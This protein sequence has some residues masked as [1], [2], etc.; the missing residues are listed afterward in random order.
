MKQLFFVFIM[1]LSLLSCEST[2]SIA[3]IIIDEIDSCKVYWVILDTSANCVD[4][5]PISIDITSEEFERLRDI[6][7]NQLPNQCISVSVTP[8]YGNSL[9]LGY[10]L[11]IDSLYKE[12]QKP[13]LD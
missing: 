10:I 9:V 4:V 12:T 13:C 5:Q 3:S 2:G 7:S 11:D 6:V 1:T 8:K